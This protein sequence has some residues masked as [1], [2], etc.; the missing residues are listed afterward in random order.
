MW[1]TYIQITPDESPSPA[2]DSYPSYDDCLEDKRDLFSA[3]LCTTVVP[4]KYMHTHMSSSYRWTRTCWFSFSFFLCVCVFFLTIA[5]LF[6]FVYSLVVLWLLVPLQSIAWEDSS[7]KWLITVYV[8]QDIE[9]NSLF[10]L[11]E[12]CKILKYNK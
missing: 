10:T 7:I 6:V 9:F 12:M 8:K 4:P 5:S 2:I 11:D 1:S 3:V